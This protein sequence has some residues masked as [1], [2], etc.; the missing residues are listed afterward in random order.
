MH[1]GKEETDLRSWRAREPARRTEGP[2]LF[3][4]REPA[5]RVTSKKE[6][7]LCVEVAKQAECRGG[8]P[9]LPEAGWRQ[10]RMRRSLYT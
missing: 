4:Y 9:A 1:K 8:L 7:R 3:S 10:N 6:G 2:G 5:E